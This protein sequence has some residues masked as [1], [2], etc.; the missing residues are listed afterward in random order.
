MIL[1]FEQ[2]LLPT[3]SRLPCADTLM[4]DGIWK[5]IRTSWCHVRSLVD[6]RHGSLAGAPEPWM[7]T[8][9]LATDGIILYPGHLEVL[10]PSNTPSDMR[11]SVQVRRR[12][13]SKNS[14]NSNYLYK[15]SSTSSALIFW[16]PSGSEST[17]PVCEVFHRICP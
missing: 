6:S 7:A 14:L 1:T 16:Y 10:I 3:N 12:T 9:H 8:K 4:S 15:S 13:V 17:Q 2:Y 11:V 5:G